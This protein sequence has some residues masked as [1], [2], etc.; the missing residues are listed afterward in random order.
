MLQYFKY[1]N[2]IDIFEYNTYPTLSTHDHLAIIYKMNSLKGRV[3]CCQNSCTKLQYGSLN[4]LCQN[5]R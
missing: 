2:L 3:Q 1:T 4:E 5:T